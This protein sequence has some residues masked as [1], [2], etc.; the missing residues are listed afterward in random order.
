MNKKR[1]FADNPDFV[2]QGE[3]LKELGIAYITFERYC[4]RLGI[5]GE[6][7]GRCTYYE[8][9]KIEQL[10]TLLDDD[11]QIWIAKIERKTGRQV[12]LV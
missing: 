7:E 6:R 9:R 11:V 5:E 10:K 4:R 8:R 12:K 2:N 1:Q 3:A